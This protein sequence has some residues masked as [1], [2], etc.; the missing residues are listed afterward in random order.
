MTALATMTVAVPALMNG[1]PE[2]M[3]GSHWKK[4]ISNAN[5]K[6][7]SFRLASSNVR[8]C[9]D[10]YLRQSK[11]ILSLGYSRE[12]FQRLTRNIKEFEA[13]VQNQMHTFPE[14]S[15]GADDAS[16]EQYEVLCKSLS[17]ANKRCE[18]F[19]HNMMRV[20]DGNHE[21]VNT[22]SV[23]KNSNQG[24]LDQ[25]NQQMTEVSQLTEA[26]F[27]DHETLENVKKLNEEEKERRRDL[28][29]RKLAELEDTHDDAFA[30]MTQF[31]E[32]KL[33]RSIA[34]L[35]AIQDGVKNL[36]EK[37]KMAKTDA[38]NFGHSYAENQRSVAKEVRLE[39]EQLGKTR[40]IEL[41]SLND[42]IHA[43]QVK[44]DA[45]KDLHAQDLE[46]WEK[47]YAALE[48]EKNEVVERLTGDLEELDAKIA[49]L[50]RRQAAHRGEHAIAEK[51]LQDEIEELDDKIQSFKLMLDSTQTS[52]SKLKSRC[53]RSDEVCEAFAEEIGFLRGEIRRGDDILTEHTSVT[54]RL[55]TEIDEHRSQG[56]NQHLT[57]MKARDDLFEQKFELTKKNIQDDVLA[58]EA[59]VRENEAALLKLHRQDASTQRAL[60]QLIEQ[61]NS[62]HRE[63]FL[64]KSE[65]DAAAKA[66][67]EVDKM[68]RENSQ[69]FEK[70]ISVLTDTLSDLQTHT[71][72]IQ[73]LYL[74]KHEEV[75]SFSDSSRVFIEEKTTFARVLQDS[76][77]EAENCLEDTKDALKHVTARL[78]EA[79]KSE[80]QMDSKNLQR[81]EYLERQKAATLAERAS[82]RRALE[83]EQEH[84]TRE[85]ETLSN[86]FARMK[87]TENAALHRASDGPNQ[88]L[89]QLESHIA[90]I[91]ERSRS[92]EA[93]L[94]AQLS[95]VR[96]EVESL[97]QENNRLE[98][99]SQEH[100]NILENHERILEERQAAYTK[101]KDRME[102][103]MARA[104]KELV[105]T[106]ETQK[107]EEEKYRQI[108]KKRESEYSALSNETGKAKMEVMTKV[109][110]TERRTKQIQV[111]LEEEKDRLVQ[112]HRL[113]SEEDN[114]KM[115]NLLR[116]NRLLRNSIAHGDLRQSYATLESPNQDALCCPSM[117]N[118][119][120]AV[121]K[122]SQSAVRSTARPFDV[123]EHL[124]LLEARGD[125]V[126]YPSRFSRERIL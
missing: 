71:G 111:E 99:A 35:H 60:D 89:F 77:L 81:I 72:K 29:K 53:S 85:Y 23:L 1:G 15:L 93:G 102:D 41:Q 54:E 109:E 63:H 34:T 79:K 119:T 82:E 21:L 30:R 68:Y 116:E 39:I 61:R 62:S 106:L 64:Q 125:E 80:A 7:E 105:A 91:Q 94:N 123:I 52:S 10:L 3:D 117:S 120:Q 124:K 95:T 4:L 19:G 27:M 75:N 13:D 73:D 58:L 49:E 57:E 28:T 16:K 110:D 118:P 67:A 56:I 112:R 100:R 46:S 32:G 20:A 31:Y 83:S 88:K 45:E 14:S 2:V 90:E 8:N 40:K 84:I 76:L 92:E 59:N 51:K 104:R 122:R 101:T 5:Q 115:E 24:F 26:S 43:L 70:G 78:A 17:D 47:R 33:Q 11:S 25:L 55:R 108:Q 37:Q 97:D 42:V 113:E 66:F 6:K 9:V 38:Q 103:E 50:Q 98:D 126:R 86:D 121:P 22:L 87:E 114:L 69:Q 48:E 107:R 18:E 36:T 44:L 12:G 65:H 74:Q 96:R